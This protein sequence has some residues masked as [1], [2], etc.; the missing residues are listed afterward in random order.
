MRN[1][2]DRF[3]PMC[4]TSEKGERLF[5][6]DAIQMTSF[7]IG[8][9]ILSLFGYAEMRNIVLQLR[10]NSHELAEV[11]DGDEM[12]SV[13]MLLGIQKVT[14]ASIDWILTGMGNKFLQNVE[15]IPRPVDSLM[16]PQPQP[17]AARIPQLW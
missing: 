1:C 8:G 12:P 2:R 5:T 15:L 14:G 9:R 16:I 3:E 11:I 17:T 6:R 4:E 10:M 7:D 13:E